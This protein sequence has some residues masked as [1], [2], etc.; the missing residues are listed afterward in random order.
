M[1]L[2]SNQVPLNKLINASVLFHLPDDP[3]DSLFRSFTVKS[4][5][6]MEDE[7]YVS[8]LLEGSE[9]FSMKWKS[10]VSHPDHQIKLED[11]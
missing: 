10:L 7:L 3:K 11:G 4:F 6:L 1:N 8:G 9:E 5:F 2:N